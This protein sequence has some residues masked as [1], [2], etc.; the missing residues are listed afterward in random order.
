MKK[1]LLILIIALFAIPTMAQWVQLSKV[2]NDAVS[3][4]FFLD[5]NTGYVAGSN[6]G[7]SSD[8]YKTADGGTTWTK[9]YSTDSGIYVELKAIWFTSS[10]NGFVAGDSNNTPLLKYTTDGGTTWKTYS[11]SFS[12]T[13][14]FGDMR[15][16][17]STTGFLTGSDLGYHGYVTTDGGATWNHMD[18][19]GSFDYFVTINF[20]DANNGYTA[21]GSYTLTK[22]TD[23]GATWN[24][25]ASVP[26][27]TFFGD[28]IIFPSSNNAILLGEDLYTGYGGLRSTDGLATWTPLSIT[29][30]ADYNVLSGIAYSDPQNVYVIGDST[31]AG[32]PFIFHSSDSGTTW[33]YMALPVAAKGYLHSIYFVGNSVGFVGGDS[34]LVLKLNLGTNV[35]QTFIA[36]RD[37]VV[38]PNPVSGYINWKTSVNNSISNDVDVSLYDVAGRLITT[39]PFSQGRINLDNLA[40]GSYILRCQDIAQLVQKE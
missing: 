9:E 38:Y 18:T 26:A 39:V 8:I 17:N 5:A 35:P 32:I 31:G 27:A 25:V 10:M 22:T 16:I 30:P 21:G 4:I 36:K 33:G 7:L 15:F 19:C 34:G 20:L 24:P 40:S 1:L 3:A 37:F 29:L 13:G 6:F 14:S 12:A 23:G 2:S 11:T 28:Q